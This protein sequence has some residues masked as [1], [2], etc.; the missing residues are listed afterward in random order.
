MFCVKS[1]KTGSI[2]ICQR[3]ESNNNENNNKDNNN[4]NSDNDNNSPATDT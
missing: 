2:Y 3:L 4:K 1:V